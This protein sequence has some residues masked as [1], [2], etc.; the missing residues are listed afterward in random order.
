MLSPARRALLYVACCAS[1][2]CLGD[3]DIVARDPM[4]EGDDAPA[5]SRG[6]SGAK[7]LDPGTPLSC[8]NPST[9]LI[10]EQGRISSIDLNTGKNAEL[11]V[12][13]CFKAATGRPSSATVDPKGR[14]WVSWSDGVLWTID[15][16]S[17]TCQSM[18]S[19]EFGATALAFVYTPGS[20]GVQLFAIEADTLLSLDPVANT[21]RSLGPGPG[22]LLA[23]GSDGQL[24]ALSQLSEGWVAI[25]DVSVEDANVTARRKVPVGGTK[26]AGAA[27]PSGE[28]MLLSFDTIYRVD[29]KLEQ[30]T[31]VAPIAPPL[32]F[33]VVAGSSCV[34]VK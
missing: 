10:D 17:L 23:T 1:G 9:F 4:R 21:R 25:Q 31:V 20:D 8:K 30:V 12:P 3:P 19:L 34:A 28:L 7:T 27:A 14:L 13:P 15:P 11:G 29:L 5:T 6:Q 26:L 2:A 18:G 24:F 22:A 33:A 32:S 16:T